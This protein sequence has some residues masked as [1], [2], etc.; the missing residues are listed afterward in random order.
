[1]ESK[2]TLQGTYG[3]SL[4]AFRKVIVKIWT[5]R[6]LTKCDGNGNAYRC[7]DYNSS[8]AL[9][10]I[11]LKRCNS[12]ACFSYIQAYLIPQYN[13]LKNDLSPLLCVAC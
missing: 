9:P 13:Y 4:N 10:T 5:S 1:M 11:E 12:F 3:P 2:L 8:F 7:G 6:K